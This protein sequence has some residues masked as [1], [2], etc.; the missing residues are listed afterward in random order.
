MQ[1]L[2]RFSSRMHHLEIPLDA[3]ACLNGGISTDQAQSR[4]T[5]SGLLGEDASLWISEH[6]NDL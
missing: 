3:Q 2:Y 4:P 6:V 5:G 1:L